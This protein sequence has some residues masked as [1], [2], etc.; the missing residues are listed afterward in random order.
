MKSLIPC[1]TGFLLWKRREPYSTF[2][3]DNEDNPGGS[4]RPRRQRRLGKN[5]KFPSRNF[6][7]SLSMDPVLRKL[8]VISLTF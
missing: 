1:M 6:G 2:D 3:I 4:G 8:K 5:L 7:F